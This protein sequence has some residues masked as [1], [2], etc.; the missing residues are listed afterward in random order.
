ME[1]R[2]RILNSSSLKEE[3]QTHTRRLVS[4][5]EL[6]ATVDEATM[7]RI[8]ELEAELYANL[9]T[10]QSISKSFEESHIDPAT[11][12]RLLKALM[13]ASF[14]AKHELEKLGLDVKEFIRNHGFLEE[15]NLAVKNLDWNVE[16]DSSI[17]EILLESPGRIAVKTSEVV[18]NF[19]TL[20]DLVKIRAS[21]EFI[22]TFLNELFIALSKYPGFSST[23]PIC[24]R[25]L[26][27]QSKL[28]DLNPSDKL[29]EKTSLELDN[30]IQIWKSEFDSIIRKACL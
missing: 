13:K 15:F 28:K 7:K 17:Y 20:S 23:H 29:D 10:L 26:E 3:L 19:I 14:K 11:F 4:E 6:L 27:W 16:A 30:A 22:S 25:I 24:K 21:C 5:R 2:E 1:G 9:A 18:S 12:K 8:Y